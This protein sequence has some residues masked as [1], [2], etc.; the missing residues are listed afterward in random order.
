MKCF[1]VGGGGE[2]HGQFQSCRC[3]YLK[4]VRRHEDVQVCL[5]VQPTT[6]LN[7]IGCFDGL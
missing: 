4:S 7:Q 2:G 1:Q 5:S 6:R 3:F